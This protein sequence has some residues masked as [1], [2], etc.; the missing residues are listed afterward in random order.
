MKNI[1][2]LA[3]LA[4]VG[5]L[6]AQ[7]QDTI[8]ECKTY[9][10]EAKDFQKT[11][12]KN[13]VSEATLAFYKDKVVVH[14]GNITSKMPYE[15]N[16]FANVLMKK[17]ITTVSNCK[18]AIKMAK[19]YDKSTHKSPFIANAHKV[20]MADNCGTLVAKKIPAFCLFDVVDNSKEDLKEK[21]LA[22]I[23]KAHATMGTDSVATYKDEV[24]ANCS[25]LHASI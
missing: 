11:M 15:K 23:D 22:S 17:D 2:I 4:T 18:L 3:L 13:K 14:C 21:C 8:S 25:K 20:N 24:L 7:A 12:H 6:N 9:I 1:L 10:N 19:A 16:F 5:L